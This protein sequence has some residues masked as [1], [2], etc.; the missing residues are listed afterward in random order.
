MSEPCR[1]VA[2]SRADLVW[3]PRKPAFFMRLADTE[4][5]QEHDVLCSSPF[6]E[7]EPG[8]LAEDLP[9]DRGLRGKTNS[10]AF[11]ATAIAAV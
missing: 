5:T 11:S 4:A 2:G 10:Q 7:A 9:I 8:Q 1:A 3:H 6:E